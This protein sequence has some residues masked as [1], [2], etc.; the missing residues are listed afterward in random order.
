[1]TQKV[2]YEVTATVDLE[3]ADDYEAFL[4]RR[5]IPDLLRTGCFESASF[6]V[7]VPGRYRIRYAAPDRKSL[8]RYFA[9][10]APRLR[11]DFATHFPEGAELS[12]EEWTVLKE[13]A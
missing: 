10:H 13:F 12:R 1:M 4:I 3:S 7:S 11:A 2:I 5:H 8:E 9:E 6:E